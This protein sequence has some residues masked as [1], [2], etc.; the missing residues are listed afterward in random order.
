MRSANWE[1]FF[2]GQEAQADDAYRDRL[3]DD[4]CKLEAKGTPLAMLQASIIR[5]ELYAIGEFDP[6]YIPEGE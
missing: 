4:L 2:Q 1:D 6:N 5:E 3:L